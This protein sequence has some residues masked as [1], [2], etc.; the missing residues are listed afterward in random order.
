M[1]SKSG[2]LLGTQNTNLK[3]TKNKKKRFGRKT[4]LF[5]P[6]CVSYFRK[7]CVRTE[8][9]NSVMR[10]SARIHTARMITV[11]GFVHDMRSYEFAS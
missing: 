7:E 3:I 8:F 6:S 10:T 1:F 5:R 2:L 11:C 9:I 4:V